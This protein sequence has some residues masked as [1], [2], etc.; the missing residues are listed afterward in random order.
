VSLKSAQ[1]ASARVLRSQKPSAVVARQRLVSSVGEWRKLGAVHTSVTA[2][3]FGPQPIA[4]AQGVA[5][6]A[7]PNPL[8]S[9]SFS[10]LLLGTAFGR[11]SFPQP[12]ALLRRPSREA[13]NP[14]QERVA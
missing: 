5:P 7:L 9:L 1:T 12:P 2:V 4:S 14:L 13:H 3:K 8:L 11:V 6:P 10:P